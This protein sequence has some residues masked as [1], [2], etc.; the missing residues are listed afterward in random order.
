MSSDVLAKR[1]KKIKPMRLLFIITFTIFPTL[2]FLLFYV[3]VNI[4]SFISAF[5]LTTLGELHWTV[6]NFQWFF[7]AVF[8]G[9][10]SLQFRNTFITFVLQQIMFVVSFFTSYF[11]YK[12][13]PMHSFFRTVFFLPTVIAATV[14][15]GIYQRIVGPYGPIA[16]IVQ[17]IL[18]LD[19]KPE[20]LADSRFANFFVLLPIVWLGIAGNMVLFGG[21]F[22]RIPDSLVESAKLDGVNWLRELF[23]II[24]PIVWPTVSVLMVINLAGVFGANG[25]VFLLTRGQNGTDTLANWMYMQVFTAD[26]AFQHNA[27]NRLS[28]VGIVLTT[29]SVALA[30][31][32]RKFTDK[33]FGEVEY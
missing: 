23:Q 26:G 32:L 8:G 4:Q 13:I 12:K 18:N 19:Y 30:L 9:E 11:L 2:H 5:Q 6:E 1:K 29:I 17:N 31:G 10:L 28:T 20:L 25:Q 24:I 14:T 16:L 15:M 3:L 21:T 7:T 33:F 27:Y 22:S